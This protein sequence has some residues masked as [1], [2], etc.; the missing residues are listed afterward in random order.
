MVLNVILLV[1]VSIL[2]AFTFVFLKVEEKDISPITIMAGRAIIA[3]FLLLALSLITKKDLLG[4]LKDWWKFFVF[5][6]FGI[7][8]SWIGIALGQEE[9]SVGLAALMDAFIPIF[10]F[11]ILVLILRE[12]PFT[13]T[14]FFGLLL[15]VIGIVLVVGIHQLL[16]ANATVK[17]LLIF[18]VAYF[19]FAANGILVERWAKNID[20]LVTSTY[21]LFFASVMLWAL[22]LIIERPEHLP[23]TTDNYV[24]EIVLGLL[25]TGVGYYSYYYLIYRAGAYFSCFIFYLLPVTGMLAGILIMHEDFRWLRLLGVPIVLAGV[26]LVNREKFKEG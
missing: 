6:L 20:A 21:F 14:G 22:A 2:W 13:F 12:L 15:G 25:C 7:T 10:T 18:L 16:A 26:Y 3:F 11:I 4:H 19:F 9:L 8:I 5:A 17:G 24:E 23:W 1:G